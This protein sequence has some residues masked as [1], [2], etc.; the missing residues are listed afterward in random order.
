MQDKLNHKFHICKSFVVGG[1]RREG[2]VVPWNFGVQN[3][4]FGQALSELHG[5]RIIKILTNANPAKTISIRFKST[6][7]LVS[8]TIC[9]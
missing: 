2:A 8:Y 1:V 6:F 3:R 9:L 7:D 4:Q 5:Y